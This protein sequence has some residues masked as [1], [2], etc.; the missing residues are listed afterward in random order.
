MHANQQTPTGWL[1][2]DAPFLSALYSGRYRAALWC[3]WRG[4][5]LSPHLA[6]L[7]T[8]ALEQS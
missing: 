6:E 8:D 2:D 5:E 1:T 7:K 3:R 4:C